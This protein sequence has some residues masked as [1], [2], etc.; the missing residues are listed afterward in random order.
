MSPRTLF[1]PEI[2]RFGER[3]SPLRQRMRGDPAFRNLHYTADAVQMMYNTNH[4]ILRGTMPAG[5]FRP[6]WKTL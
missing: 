4:A 2:D 1:E 6:R 3:F 5:D